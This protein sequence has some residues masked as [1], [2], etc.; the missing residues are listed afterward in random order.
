MYF[1]FTYIY[2]YSQDFFIFIVVCFFLYLST[3]ELSEY[4]ES[5]KP[6]T[7]V[8]SSLSYKM[9]TFTFSFF[10][11]SVGYISPPGFQKSVCFSFTDISI[12][13]RDRRT[14]F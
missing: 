12:V 1:L 4:H 7:A 14:V 8:S 3:D 11:I 10:N 6:V 2:L 13:F 9:N 5:N